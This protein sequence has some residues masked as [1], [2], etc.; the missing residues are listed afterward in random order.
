MMLMLRYIFFF[1]STSCCYKRTSMNFIGNSFDMASQHLYFLNRVQVSI[2]STLYVQIFRTN[3]VFSSYMYVEK[4]MFV[5]KIR[6]YN[7]D[8]IDTMVTFVVSWKLNKHY[9][10]SSLRNLFLST[11]L[12]S[13][14]PAGGFLFLTQWGPPYPRS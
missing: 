10:R 2:S 9:Y 12:V 6:M 14:S 7:V 4:T 1:F 8:E 11:N 13:P 3:V 5:R